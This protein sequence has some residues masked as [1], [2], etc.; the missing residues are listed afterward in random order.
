MKFI[1]G[2]RAG[3]IWDAEND[4]PLADFVKGI[5]ETS[6]ETVIEKLTELG[7]DFEVPKRLQKLKKDGK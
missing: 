1:Q 4:K 5:F 7:F 3:L 2:E 6:D